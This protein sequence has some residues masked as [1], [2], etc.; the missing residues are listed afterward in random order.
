MR[1]RKRLFSCI[2]DNLQQCCILFEVK[3]D[4]I[5]DCWLSLGFFSLL[6]LRHVYDDWH[7][8][9]MLF[10]HFLK[11][12]F[13][14]LYWT[15]IYDAISFPSVCLTFIHCFRSIS[16][17]FADFPGVLGSSSLVSAVCLEYKIFPSRVCWADGFV[18]L[19]WVDES[20][21][22]FWSSHWNNFTYFNTSKMVF[23]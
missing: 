18:H 3:T 23:F 22:F 21:V 9:F 10:I 11:E 13:F 7:P 17:A 6:W 19:H 1:N 15:H 20:S 4:F 12:S 2:I 5:V 14:L 8:G 16:Q